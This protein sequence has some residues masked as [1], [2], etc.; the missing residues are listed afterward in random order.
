MHLGSPTQILWVLVRMYLCMRME[1]LEVEMY[2][3]S[4]IRVGRKWSWIVTSSCEFYKSF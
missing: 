4:Q 1:W 2:K 3:G